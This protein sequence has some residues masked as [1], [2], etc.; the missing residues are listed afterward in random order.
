MFATEE[1]VMSQ[2]VTVLFNLSFIGR[3]DA[4]IKGRSGDAIQGYELRVENEFYPAAVGLATQ[5]KGGWF[6]SPTDKFWDHLPEV[7]EAIS[8]A[9]RYEQQQE[10]LRQKQEEETR[11]LQEEK[12]KLHD[13]EVE[14][15]LTCPIEDCAEVR[16]GEYSR[17]SGPWN[18]PRLADRA[19]QVDSWC[20]QKNDEI[21]AKMLEEK[22]SERRE[23]AARKEKY[24]ADMEAWIAQH[25]SERLKR[26]I[27]EGISCQGIY[28]D[29]RIAKEYPGWVKYSDLEEVVRD[30]VN[31]PAEAFVI[32]DLA[33]KTV[34]SAKLQFYK[35][36]SIGVYCA[37]AEWP[38]AP[39]ELDIVFF[40]D[41]EYIPVSEY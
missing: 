26:C 7:G 1:E 33:R 14:R 38:V 20:K 2:K 15:T 8:E 21:S 16:W 17:K 23:Q 37:H 22:E 4:M 39:D 41:Q 6:V 27:Q 36:K 18:D 3:K 9:V 40:G 10:V 25:G 12:Q 34:P 5:D 13:Q 29:E 31:P 30:P 11:R 32:L 19:A 24:K 35:D 28:R